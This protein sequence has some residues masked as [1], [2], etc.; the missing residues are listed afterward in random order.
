[1][2]KTKDADLKVGD[3]LDKQVFNVS[4]FYKGLRF[5]YTA[6]HQKAIKELYNCQIVLL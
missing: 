3:T 5:E 4:V 2:N 6:S 1:M